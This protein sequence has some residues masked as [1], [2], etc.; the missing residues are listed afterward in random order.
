LLAREGRE[1]RPFDANDL[2]NADARTLITTRR[3]AETLGFF[4]EEAVVN[5]IN[6]IDLF[7][8]QRAVSIPM[9]EPDLVV[10]RAAIR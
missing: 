10:E 6:R 3:L 4:P 5:Q 8:P 9:Q 7:S 1:V 2:L